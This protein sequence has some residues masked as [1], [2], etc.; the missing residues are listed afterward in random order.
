MTREYGRAI[1]DAVAEQDSSDRPVLIDDLV[2]CGRECLLYEPSSG[3]FAYM[4]T[5]AESYADDD[6]HLVGVL[7]T[8]IGDMMD[9]HDRGHLLRAIRTGALSE[10]DVADLFKD[11]VE[12]MAARPTQSRSDSSPSRATTGRPSTAASR[13]VVR[14]PS[15]SGRTGS[16]TRSTTT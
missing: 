6:V 2:I 13:R 3:G 15:T 9:A 1:E 10:D 7:L 5:V 16:S 4:L 11:I 8:F 14:T 12:K